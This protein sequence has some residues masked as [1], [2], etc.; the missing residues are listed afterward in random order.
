MDIKNIPFEI[1]DL[2]QVIPE[3]HKGETG[4]AHWKTIQRGN[5]RMRIVEY[6]SGYLADHWCEK[7]H[8]VFV[9]EGAF[10]SELKDGRKDT[11]TKGMAYL[12]ADH[13]DAHRS[14]SE[15]GVKLLIV[16]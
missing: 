15:N 12:V 8:A 14:Y 5:V 7:G 4:T 10:V 3:E 9:L 16:D 13:A 6:G 11:L 1:F 2:E